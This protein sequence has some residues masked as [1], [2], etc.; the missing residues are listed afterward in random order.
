MIGWVFLLLA[1]GFEVAAATSMKMSDGFSRVWPSILMVVFYGLCFVAMVKSL[2]YIQLGAM[3]AIWAG[4][5][6]AAIALIGVMY[7]GDSMPWA[8]VLGMGLI[9]IGVVMVN[10]SGVHNP[11]KHAELSEPVPS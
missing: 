2:E 6:T 3:Y 10:L 11:P 1:I 9:I 5:G 8:K 4:L 7:F